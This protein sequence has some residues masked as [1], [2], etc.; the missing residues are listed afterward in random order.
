L[1]GDK[2]IDIRRQTNRRISDNFTAQRNERF[3]LY[4]ES[5]DNQFTIEF[6]KSF[7]KLRVAKRLTVGKTLHQMDTLTGNGTWATTA[8]ASNLR[9][10][11][12]TKVQGAASLRYDFTGASTSGFIENST[13]T[14]IDA[15]A[16]E[17]IGALFLRRFFPDASAVTSINLRWGSSVSAFWDRTVTVAHDTTAFVNGFNRLRFDW[18]GATQTGSPNAAALNYARITTVYDGVADTDHRDDDLTISLGALFEIVYYS[19]FLFRDT[20]TNVFQEKVTADTNIVNLDTES[21]N[22]LLYE[23]MVLIAQQLQGEDGILDIQFYEEK[24]LEAYRE[25]ADQYPSEK[26]KV[27]GFYYR[28]FGRSS[29]RGRGI[30]RAANEG[31]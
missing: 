15:S 27:T 13:M 18:N 2:I 20:T 23:I 3:D 19:K 24:R 30:S 10:D 4:K 6:D 9:T 5:S 28:P 31:R 12:L 11:A 8:D 16:E 21:Y 22:L 29:R 7:K 14:A 26:E 25:Y 17:D 1:K